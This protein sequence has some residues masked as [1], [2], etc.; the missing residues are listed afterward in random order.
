DP[1]PL[2]ACLRHGHDLQK[3]PVRILEVEAPS[4]AASVDLAVLVIIRLAAIE[5]FL[6]RDP[7]EYRFELR[8][9]DVEGVVKAPAGSRIEAR[10]APILRLV[11]EVERQAIVDLHLRE[12]ARA[13]LDR[14]SEDVCEEPGRGD[15]VFRGDD[16]VVESDG[17]D[18]PPGGPSI[19]P[20][21]SWISRARS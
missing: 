15:L 14:Q 9:A 18:P 12:V 7:M 21:A 11:G 2:T 8:I 4:A 5:D 16:G 13:R 10:S 1:R 19:A 6:G 3:V 17:H 20:C